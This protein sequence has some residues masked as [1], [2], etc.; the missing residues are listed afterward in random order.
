M[1]DELLAV[2]S[3]VHVVS[4]LDTGI[5][6][7]CDRPSL[8]GAWYVHA[9]QVKPHVYPP[10]LTGWT[11]EHIVS[12]LLIKGRHTVILFPEELFGLHES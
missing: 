1:R 6:K 10:R 8:G 3:R 2:S 4:V 7:P 5:L 12:C 9:C 11:V